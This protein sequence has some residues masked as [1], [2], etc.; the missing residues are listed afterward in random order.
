MCM[1]LGHAVQ[2]FVDVCLRNPSSRGILAR[3]CDQVVN[4][5]K[6]ATEE[7]V[8]HQAQ[9]RWAENLKGHNAL[10]ITPRAILVKSV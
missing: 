9:K 3:R 10:R 4:A 7:G 2:K 6:R 1:V 5:G 8:V